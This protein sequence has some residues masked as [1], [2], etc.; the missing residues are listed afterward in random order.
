[1]KA[2]A[3]VVAD[4]TPLNDMIVT[5][6]GEGLEAPFPGTIPLWHGG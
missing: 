6:P 5:A 2:L 4:T 1:M 3:V